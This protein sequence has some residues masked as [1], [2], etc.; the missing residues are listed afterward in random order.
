MKSVFLGLAGLVI[1]S[2]LMVGCYNRSGDFTMITTK[3]YVAGAKYKMAGRM[4]GEDMVME[5]IIPLGVP[6]MKTAVDNTIQ[7]APGGVYLANAVI[8]QGGWYAL[9]V[10]SM[11]YRVTGDVYANLDQGDLVNPAI[12]KFDVKSTPTGLEM[13]SE[14][15]GKSVHV[16]TY[17]DL[18]K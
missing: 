12:E 18:A 13:V 2:T 1:A 14:K 8:E 5:I 3:N 9:L 15:T 6:N 11:G 17:A 16:Q 10:G 7:S 4:T